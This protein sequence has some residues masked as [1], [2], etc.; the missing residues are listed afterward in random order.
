MSAPPRLLGDLLAA[1]L[2][3]LCALFGVFKSLFT[4]TFGAGARFGSWLYVFGLYAGAGFLLAIV[5][6]QAGRRWRLWLGI[7]AGIVAAR[8]AVTEPGTLLIDLAAFGAAMAGILAG[9]T[10]GRRMRIPTR[11]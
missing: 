10:G 3:L 8:C 7:P 6:P 11:G 4:D 1:A 2:S 5:W 9:T